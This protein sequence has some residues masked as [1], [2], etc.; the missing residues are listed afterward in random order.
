M[1][2]TSDSLR[3]RRLSQAVEAFLAFRQAGGADPQSLFAAHP[4]L[5]DLLEPMVCAESPPTPRQDDRFVA[6]F[7]LLREIGRGGMG[8]V[9]EAQELALGRRV[10]LKVLPAQLGITPRNVERFRREAAA[11]ARLKHPG[12][13]PVYQVGEVDGTHY[14]AMELIDGRSIGQVL[15][16]LRER[17]GSDPGAVIELGIPGKDGGY[18]AAAAEIVEQAAAAVAAAHEGGILHR[19]IKPHNLL[20]AADGS[21][22]VVD[23]GLAKDLERRGISR[24]GEVSGTPHYMSP[25][26]TFGSKDVDERS[27][28]YSLGVVLYELLTLRTPF[29]AETTQAVFRAI[30]NDE[31]LAPRRFNPRVPRELETICLTALEKDPRHRYPSAASLAADLRRFVRHE[32]VAARPPGSVTRLLKLLRRRRATV[33]AIVLGFVVV[34]IAPIGFALYQRGVNRE[35]AR[36]QQE[37]ER[38][39]DLARA[40]FERAQRF[41][42]QQLDRVAQFAREPGMELV[43]RQMAEDALRCYRDIEATDHGDG[44]LTAAL[45]TRV[46]VGRIHHHLGAHAE[47][48]AALDAAVARAAQEA[49]PSA[50]LVLGGA[51]ARRWRAA[52]LRALG[53]RDAAARDLAR[54]RAAVDEL[55]AT[56]PTRAAQVAAA[57]L[58][59][60]SGRYASEDGRDVAAALPGLERAAELLR[61]APRTREQT[62]MSI[63]VLRQ[64]SETHR[65]LGKPALGRPLLEEARAELS[66]VTAED[67]R[68]PMIRVAQAQV[69]V[70][71]GALQ[72]DVGDS[73]AAE[74]S[75]QQGVTMREAL[76]RDFPHNQGHR[77]GLEV[78]LTNLSFVLA[79]NRKPAESLACGER[80]E[81]L[82][83]A[84]LEE[85]EGSVL[86]ATRVCFTSNQLCR[87]RY[88]LRDTSVDREAAFLHAI[89]LHRRVAARFPDIPRIRSQVGAI[90]NNYVR[91]L[92]SV[93]QFDKALVVID[94]AIDHQRAALAADPSVL[95]YRMFLANHLTLVA[96]I[97]A[98]RGAFAAVEPAAR[99]MLT[100]TDNT[101]QLATA[102]KY[103]VRCALALRAAPEADLARA[104]R[105]ER[106][107][108]AVIVTALQRQPDPDVRSRLGVDDVLR[109]LSRYPEFAALLP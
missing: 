90:I 109:T 22:R 76:V 30:A 53:E 79:A 93:E 82:A 60:D 28:V 78:C 70:E 23:F 42:E 101:Y 65:A 75:F 3:F 98:R 6:G 37:T 26:Q 39:R 17:C 92:V 9:Y 2:P 94:E 5:R 95:Q 99:E 48:R 13:V 97:H 57:A 86:L 35:I 25:E 68:D 100:V 77:H 108:V 106:D 73:K 12:I 38:Q 102:A 56:T 63:D 20:L 14:F 51:E 21:V 91:Q 46:L 105:L 7:R 62:V 31:P 15:N 27:D 96:D 85:A 32:P 52:V 45:G 50:E 29:D 69:A 16:E 64:L 44:V 71:L 36:E 24:T 19:D 107:A 10:A 1:K 58:L 84:L 88:D 11:A 43:Q 49:N 4:D 103:L 33:V 74:A 83:L 54:A 89:E 66:T 40:N 81:K 61:A 80:A 55:L 87:L 34:V 41:V 47:A 8:V 59:L 104:E 18:F 72:R 67:A